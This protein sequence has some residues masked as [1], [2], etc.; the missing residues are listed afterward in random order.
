MAKKV[1]LRNAFVKWSRLYKDLYLIGNQC[2][3]GGDESE[4]INRGFYFGILD[5]PY[6]ELFQKMKN[7]SDV[8]YIPSVTDAKDNIE[9]SLQ[10]L[11]N[12]SA[13]EEIKERFDS[14]YEKVR[15]Q[16]EWLPVPLTEEEIEK[17]M[18][19]GQPI[20]ITFD[21]EKPIV[22]TKSIFP[23]LTPKTI[24]EITYFTDHAQNDQILH[25]Y[26]KMTLECFTLFM[27]YSF[28]L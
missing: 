5:Q 1:E 6:A 19:N 7:E 18:K 9:N 28:L 11:K 17:M 20:K 26:F 15:N 21:G 16:E 12:Q 24:P 4:R 2:F 14:L 25:V 10:P 3:C 27:K 23:G 22:V 8:I 13:V